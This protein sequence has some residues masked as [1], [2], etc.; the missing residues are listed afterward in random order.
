MTASLLNSP[1]EAIDMI[2]EIKPRSQKGFPA[3]TIMIDG[4]CIGCAAAKA[5]KILETVV[6]KAT[7]TAFTNAAGTLTIKSHGMI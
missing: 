4:E 7:F 5:V 3:V 2:R 6:S 1:N